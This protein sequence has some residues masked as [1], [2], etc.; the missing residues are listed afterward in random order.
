MSLLTHQIISLLC[1]SHVAGQAVPVVSILAK[2]ARIARIRSSYAGTAQGD[3][4]LR[5]KH[6]APTGT[7]PAKKNSAKADSSGE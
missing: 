7:N 2:A 1:E 4:L 5:L 6:I 3:Y